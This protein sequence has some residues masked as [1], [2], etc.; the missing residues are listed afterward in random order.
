[1]HGDI[2]GKRTRAWAQRFHTVRAA[3]YAITELEGP[4]SGYFGAYSNYFAC[5]IDL[6]GREISTVVDELRCGKG[7]QRTP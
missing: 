7:E 1:M 3:G 4:G 6:D 5:A 2:L